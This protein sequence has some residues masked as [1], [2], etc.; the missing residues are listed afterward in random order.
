[1]RKRKEQSQREAPAA[2]AS[3]DVAAAW[4]V[5]VPV[6]PPLPEV[7]ETPVEIPIT[8]SPKRQPKV[9]GRLRVVRE[10]LANV[11]GSFTR[12]TEGQILDPLGYSTAVIE[13]LRSQG[14]KLE[15]VE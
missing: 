10:A 1:M 6:P 15:P 4:P 12:L 2:P 7:E 14:V 8:A 11:N 13:S 3:D 5:G 9:S